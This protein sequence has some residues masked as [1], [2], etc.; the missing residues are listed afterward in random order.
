[1]V[2]AVY[3]RQITTDSARIHITKPKYVMR[4][5]RVAYITRRLI[6]MTSSAM[7][8]NVAVKA[9]ALEGLSSNQALSEKGILISISTR[10]N[11]AVKVTVPIIWNFPRKYPGSVC[12]SFTPISPQK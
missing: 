2:K 6:M 11:S 7:A 4:I 12:F 1:M 3:S 9:K 10:E 8:K 5:L